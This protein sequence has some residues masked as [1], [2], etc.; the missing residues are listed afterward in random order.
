MA[1][2]PE[3]IMSSLSLASRQPGL[4]FEGDFQELVGFAAMAFPPVN[5]PPQPSFS[6]HR[7]IRLLV[8][9]IAGLLGL[10]CA[11]AHDDGRTG[12]VCPRCVSQ[13]AP[14]DLGFV[15]SGYC[16]GCGESFLAFR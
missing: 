2:D 13:R 14:P 16:Q 9:G 4:G 3:L 12:R 6:R 11:L 10:C 5:P 15:R 8:S 1:T 7:R